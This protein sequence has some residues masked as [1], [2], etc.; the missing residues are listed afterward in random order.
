LNAAH[1]DCRIVMAFIY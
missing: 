1:S